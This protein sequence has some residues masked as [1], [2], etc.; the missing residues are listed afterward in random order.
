VKRIYS[1]LALFSLIGVFVGFKYATTSI[2][3]NY[4]H[5]TSF[6]DAFQQFGYAHVIRQNDPDFY[7]H[8]KKA[9]LKMQKKSDAIDPVLLAAIISE[10]IK[11][12]AVNLKYV[13]EEETK[14]LFMSLMGFWQLVHKNETPKVCNSIVGGGQLN[15][16]GQKV[17]LYKEVIDT[18]AKQVLKYSYKYKRQPAS[19]DLVPLFRGYKIS[20]SELY[21]EQPK[22]VQDYAYY[23]PENLDYCDSVIKLGQLMIDKGDENSIRFMKFMILSMYEV[24]T[25]EDIMSIKQEI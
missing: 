10:Y 19:F 4:R 20:I 25:E 22:I 17:H 2:I 8:L 21:E 6:D 11:R 16:I 3:E 24:V 18:R 13:S 12:N 9:T 15:L 7:S 23:N 1:A 5:S 14:I